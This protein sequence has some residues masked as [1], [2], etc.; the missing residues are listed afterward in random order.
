MENNLPS[1]WKMK[2]MNRKLCWTVRQMR[3]L[4]L[5]VALKEDFVIIIFFSSR[6]I[7]WYFYELEDS[8]E[9]VA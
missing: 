7:P 2:G 9:R 1:M 5:N 4:L 8:K 6:K 3:D